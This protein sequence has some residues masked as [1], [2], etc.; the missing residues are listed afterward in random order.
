[1][2][3]TGKEDLRDQLNLMAAQVVAPSYR[4][5]IAEQY[6]DQMRA[7]YPTHDATP[8]S[9]AAKEVPRLIRSGDTR[10][11]YS[12]LD[13]FL[14]PTIADVREWLDPQFENGMIEITVV[15][16]VDKA[17]VIAEVART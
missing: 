3:A 7:W 1:L 16:D 15:G 17:S 4:E 14:A 12:D 2:G 8:T 9:V 13:M 6:R 11:G 10:Y 5:T